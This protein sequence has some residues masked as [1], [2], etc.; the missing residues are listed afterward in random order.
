MTIKFNETNNLINIVVDFKSGPEWNEE[1]FWSVDSKKIES[2][3]DKIIFKSQ[4]IDI[5]NP[6][7]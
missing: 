7:P 1:Y 3:N 5:N 6:E 2:N 4:N